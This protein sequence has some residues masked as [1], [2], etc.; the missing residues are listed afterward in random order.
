[1]K[2]VTSTATAAVQSKSNSHVTVYCQPV[3][4]AS[5]VFAVLFLRRR[6]CC[7]EATISAHNCPSDLLG[8]CWCHGGASTSQVVSK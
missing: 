7:L 5:C 4:F 2:F 8:G 3:E 6:R 1:M